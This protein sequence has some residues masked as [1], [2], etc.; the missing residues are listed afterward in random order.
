MLVRRLFLSTL[1]AFTASTAFAQNTTEEQLDPRYR[2]RAEAMWK[3]M[4]NKDG[5]I[6]QK[7][8]MDMVTEQWKKM[9]KGGKGMITSAD[10]ARIM[11]FLSGQGTAP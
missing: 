8:F 9:D 4:A 1:L 6:M 2:A 7:Q 3:K 5:M 11:V 10:A